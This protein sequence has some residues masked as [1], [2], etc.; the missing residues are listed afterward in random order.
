[1]TKSNIFS[2]ICYCVENMIIGITGTLGAGKGTVVDYLLEKKGF[3]HFSVRSFLTEELEKRGLPVNRDEMRILADELRKTKSL[4]YIAEELLAQAKESGANSIIESIRN[5][6]EIELLRKEKSFRLFAVDA[7]PKI[8]YERISKRKSSTDDVSFE[9]FMEQER[10]ESN[11]DNPWNMNLPE[12]MRRA[13]FVL[14]N[15]ETPEVLY[16]QIEKALAEI[17]Q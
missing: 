4:G 10:R 11:P 14:Q 13:N 16:A 5:V 2:E 7:E 8:R 12:C 9:K 3:R 1:M 17:K 15:N 6:G